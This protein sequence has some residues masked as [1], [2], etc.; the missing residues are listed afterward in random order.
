LPS[1]REYLRMYKRNVRPFYSIYIPPVLSYLLCY[2]WEKYSI[3]SEGQLPPVYGRSSWHA[4]WKKTRYSNE[5]VKRKLGWQARIGT[6]EALDGFF[7]SCRS[8]SRH[9]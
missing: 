2:L 9:G 5:K 7:E 4:Y 1:S 8:R 6:P 3:W